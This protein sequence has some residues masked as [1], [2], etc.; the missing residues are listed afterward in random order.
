MYS[1]E[2]LIFRIYSRLFLRCRSLAH[3][4]QY[5]LELPEFGISTPH[6]T[7]IR[8]NRLCVDILNI[9]LNSM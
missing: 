1:P 9:S 5:F 7:H 4:V 2:F 3:S 8:V 6:E